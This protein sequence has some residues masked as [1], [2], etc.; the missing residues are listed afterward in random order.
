MPYI[1]HHM[2][3]THASHGIAK[4]HTYTNIIRE[5]ERPCS[6]TYPRVLGGLSLA[7]FHPKKLLLRFY[8]TKTHWDANQDENFHP[9]H[10]KLLSFPIP[11]Q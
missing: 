1:H 6:Y 10:H 2:V 7:L 8:Y 4:I 5:R 11:A 3:G 9:Q